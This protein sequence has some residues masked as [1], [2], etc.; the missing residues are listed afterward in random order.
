MQTHT[1]THPKLNKNLM[2]LIFSN[3]DNIFYQIEKI[4]NKAL[5]HY[6]L[7]HKKS[8]LYHFLKNSPKLKFESIKINK[9]V[10]S[11]LNIEDI[12]KNCYLL[13]FLDG[14]IKAYD[15][16]NFKEIRTYS[17]HQSKVTSLANMNNYKPGYFASSSIKFEIVIWDF[18]LNFSIFTFEV[19]LF[20]SKIFYPFKFNKDLLVISTFSNIIYL[21]DL[22][23][24]DNKNYEL[25]SFSIVENISNQDDNEDDENLKL[26]SINYIEQVP[27]EPYN[28]I[29]LAS[30]NIY[31]V[32]LQ[33]HTKI[34]EFQTN[35]NYG[36]NTMEFINQN[37][38][39]VSTEKEC[40]TI[41]KLKYNLKVF[42][43]Y[44]F[45]KKIFRIITVPDEHIMLMFWQ[46]MKAKNKITL[47][48]INNFQEIETIPINFNVS[49]VSFTKE[50]KILF[51]VGS[52]D[53][54]IFTLKI[55]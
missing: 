29:L 38:F 55:N 51:L 26:P 44:E 35:Y 6:Y 28:L 18:N 43:K 14:S 49:Q 50:F 47:Y 37:E 22:N 39:L 24:L 2:Y 32:D 10:S 53:N 30:R 5:H 23:N 46:D 25:S 1:P 33:T 54:E 48:N 4:K 36:I 16:S 27:I 19:Q 20:I 8:V 42:E 17:E 31:I 40:F 12:C 7:A 9:I 52:K 45:S 21:L 3:L 34:C 13:G 41:F 15:V 11:I